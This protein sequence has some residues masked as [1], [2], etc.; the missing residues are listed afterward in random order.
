[1]APF[2]HYFYGPVKLSLRG[3]GSAVLAAEAARQRHARVGSS[4]RRDLF[5]FP[6]M[7]V[8]SAKWV[9]G[10]EGPGRWK[11]P[12]WDMRDVRVR[13]STLRLSA[14]HRPIPPLTSTPRPLGRGV[15][16]VL[17]FIRNGVGAVI[18]TGEERYG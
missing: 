9:S 2:T 12:L 6:I 18:L 1:M 8:S 7:D 16:S 17:T 4:R 13:G 10:E 14:H 11:S 5:S 3:W 15:F